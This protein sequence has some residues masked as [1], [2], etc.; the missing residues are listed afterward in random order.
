MK[1][2]NVM[3]NLRMQ[4]LF[5]YVMKIKRYDHFFVKNLN[6][7]SMGAK[8]LSQ[9]IIQKKKPKKSF[10]CVDFYIQGKL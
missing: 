9:I 8:K 7:S 5:A 6:T 1:M 3:L 2:D 4:F 10:Y